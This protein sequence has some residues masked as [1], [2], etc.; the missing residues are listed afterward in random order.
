MFAI[1][2]IEFVKRSSRKNWLLVAIEEQITDTDFDLA[3]WRVHDDYM[4][5]EDP[6]GQ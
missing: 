5:N 3:L 1:P 4:D 6:M 2:M